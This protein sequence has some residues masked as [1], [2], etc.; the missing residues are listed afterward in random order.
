MPEM[1]P[2]ELRTLAVAKFGPDWTAKLAKATGVNHAT[3][4]RWAG[5]VWPITDRVATHVRAVCE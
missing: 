3:V 4:E 5:G 2:S 1:T